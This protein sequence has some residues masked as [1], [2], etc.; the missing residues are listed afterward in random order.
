MAGQT[1][2]TV[3]GLTLMQIMSL[4]QPLSSLLSCLFNRHMCAV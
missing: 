3:H 1:V 4:Q 2:S